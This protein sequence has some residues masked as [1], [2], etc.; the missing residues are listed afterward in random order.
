MRLV[1]AEV[2]NVLE[3]ATQVATL[4]EGLATLLAYERT[5]ASMFS[6]MVP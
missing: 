4:G 3:M 5:L 1:A 6:E 2:V